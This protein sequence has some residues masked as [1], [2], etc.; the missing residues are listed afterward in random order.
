MPNRKLEIYIARNG[1]V[2]PG[3]N[4]ETGSLP[5]PIDRGSFWNNLL[6]ESNP[7]E[8]SIYIPNLPPISGGILNRWIKITSRYNDL[9]EEFNDRIGTAAPQI[10]SPQRSAFL[11]QK[12]TKLKAKMASARSRLIDLAYM[13]NDKILTMR[14]ESP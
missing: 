12:S 2:I 6:P 5:G 4:G 8:P 9:V 3:D 11:Q 13:H 7:D 14:A 10:P 1:D